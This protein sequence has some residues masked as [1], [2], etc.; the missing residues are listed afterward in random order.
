MNNATIAL[1][2]FVINYYVQYYGGTNTLAAYGVAIRIEQL[3]LVPAVGINVAVISL[4]GRSFGA[5]SIDRIYTVWKRATIGGLIIMGVGVLLIVPFA[6]FLISFFDDKPAVVDAGARYL[7]IEAFAFFSYIFLNVGVA[8]LQ[9][10]KHPAY[11]LYIGVFR[12]LVPIGLFY[13]LGTIL[14]MG[15]DGV[16]WGIVIINWIAVAITLLYASYV[17]RKIRKRLN[18]DSV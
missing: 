17:L 6:P 13:F 5:K 11:A 9:G 8:L 14:S 18:Q 12:Q 4:V 10:V 16:W 15:I 3:A 7:R 2:V 1:G